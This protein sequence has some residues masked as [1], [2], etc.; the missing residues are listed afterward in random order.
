LFVCLFA[1]TSQPIFTKFD[2]KVAHGPQKT[3]SNIRGNSD[4]VTLSL[5]LDGS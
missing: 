2:G 4:H 1:K 3:P 5:Q